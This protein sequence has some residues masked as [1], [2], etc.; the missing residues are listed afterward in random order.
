[1]NV[2]ALSAQGEKEERVHLPAQDW[3][4]PPSGQRYDLWGVNSLAFP[5][6]TCMSSEKVPM[7]A[8]ARAFTDKPKGM[9]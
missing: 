8:P 1:M 4:L 5:G 3:P 2:S 7:V 9:K 6:C